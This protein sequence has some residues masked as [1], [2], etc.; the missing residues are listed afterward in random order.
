M[1]SAH[2]PYIEL[3]EAI[4][5]YLVES[6]QSNHKYF[7]LFHLA[8]RAITE[9]G[10][11]FFYQVKSVRLPVLANLT[12]T[13]PPDYLNYS[14]IGVLNNEGEIIP[15]GVNTN[16]TG[17]AGQLTTRLQQTQD[18]TLQL[19][20]VG[21]TPIWYNYWYGEGYTNLY[22]VPSGSPF[23]GSFKID[24]ANGIILLNETFGYPYIML[25]YIAS[26]L[27]GQTYY[28]PIQFKEAVISYLRWKDIISMPAGNKRSLLGDK[29]QRRHEYFNERRLAIAR[30]KPLYL[31]EAYDA[32]LQ[33]QRL[34]VKV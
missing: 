28:L 17:F 5:G 30:Y 26:P 27:E 19:P 6:E 22:G 20:I 31:E 34:T 4:T 14:K 29:A 18:T 33:N 15:M 23:I 13:L 7:K 11:D 8:F 24:I 25:E 32:N 16:L 3:D 2:Q 21:Q 1:S 10:L 12:V 9:L